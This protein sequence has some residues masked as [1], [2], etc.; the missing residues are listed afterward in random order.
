M[1]RYASTLNP[2]A[3]VPQP[4]S[5]CDEQIFQR[6]VFPEKRVALMP[7]AL[8]PTCTGL[9]PP[10]VWRAVDLAHARNGQRVRIAGNVICRQC[11]EAAKGFVFISLE[12]ETGIANAILN[13]RE[14]NPGGSGST[15]SPDPKEQ[16]AANAKRRTRKAAAPRR[17]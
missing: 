9:L 6:A 3:F 16:S 7:D 4:F 1:P 5:Y 11:P 2:I 15:K 14:D 17:R 8:A 10:E 12:D 13:R